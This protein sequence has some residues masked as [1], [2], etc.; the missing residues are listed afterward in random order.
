M[1]SGRT[2]LNISSSEYSVRRK[3]CSAKQHFCECPGEAIQ[4][5]FPTDCLRITRF[6]WSVHYFCK[7]WWSAAPNQLA[8]LMVLKQTSTESSLPSSRINFLLYVLTSMRIYCCR[9]F[10]WILVFQMPWQFLIPKLL[11]KVF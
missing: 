9:G 3:K 10:C 1:L 11:D 6:W 7:Y 4:W 5:L 2:V 8:H